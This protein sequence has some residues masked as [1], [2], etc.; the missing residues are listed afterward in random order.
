[1]NTREKH[2]PTR[3]KHWP[4]RGGQGGQAVLG[5]QAAN[6]LIRPTASRSGT[7]DKVNFDKLHVIVSTLF[8]LSF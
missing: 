6:G 8:V 1:M 3:G 7:T 4:T 5:P 2:W